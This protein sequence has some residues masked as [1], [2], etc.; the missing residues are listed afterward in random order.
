MYG[1]FWDGM[2]IMFLI[3]LYVERILNLFFCS[4]IMDVFLI[5]GFKGPTNLAYIF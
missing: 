1:A 4:R 2:N 5:P 3:G